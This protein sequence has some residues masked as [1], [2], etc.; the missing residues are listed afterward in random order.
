MGRSIP[1]IF[2]EVKKAMSQQ[3]GCQSEKDVDGESERLHNL[4]SVLLTNKTICQ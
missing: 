1:A 4:V 3:K 2:A